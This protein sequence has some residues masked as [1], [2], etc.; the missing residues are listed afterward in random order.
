MRPTGPLTRAVSCVRPQRLELES[1]L[2]SVPRRV[3]EAGLGVDARVLSV[4]D[5]GRGGVD[6][7]RHEFRGENLRDIP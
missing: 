7:L 3:L 5:G 4:D 1:A 2:R 6:D